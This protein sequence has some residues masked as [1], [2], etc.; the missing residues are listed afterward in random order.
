MRPALSA[1]QYCNLAWG[2]IG[3]I[4]ER[5]TGERFDR[6]MKRL[7][8][9]PLRVERW[10]SSVRSQP[11]ICRTGD[12]LYRKLNGLLGGRSGTLPAPGL[13]RSMTMSKSDRLPVLLRT[14][15]RAATAPCL[16]RK[17]IAGRQRVSA[18]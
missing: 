14:M 18:A 2:V 12:A 13:L 17:A 10:L 11:A 8:L 5:A 9:D 1:F 15:S 3:S 6:L 7:V 16:V 4:M